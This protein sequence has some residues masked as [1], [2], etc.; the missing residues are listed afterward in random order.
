MISWVVTPCVRVY[1]YQHLKG[2]S[3]L[4]PRIIRLE[5]LPERNDHASATKMDVIVKYLKNWHVE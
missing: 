2:I 1:W 4:L 3:S 5:V